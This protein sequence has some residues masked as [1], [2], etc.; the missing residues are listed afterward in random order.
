MSGYHI[1][2]HA[3]RTPDRIACKFMPSGTALTFGQL[4]RRSNRAAHL[5]RGLGL[6]RGDVIAILM[7]NHPRYYEIAWAAD[8]AGLYYTGISSRLTPSEIAYIIEDSGAAALFTSASLAN[9]AAEALQGQDNCTGFHVDGAAEG[10]RDYLVEVEELPDMPVADES[11]GA[12]MLYSSGTTGRPKGVKFPLPEGRIDQLDRLTAIT[13]ERFAY[14]DDMIYLSP[15]PLYHA[16]PLRWSMCAQRCGGTVVVM[17]KF[18]AESALALVESE[19]ITHSQWVPTHFIRMLKLPEAARTRHDLSS[20]RIAFHAAAPCP[21]PV[22]QAM[23]DWWGPILHEYYAGTEFN[24]LTSI[25]PEEWRA[26]PGSVGQ[27]SV[28]IIHICADDGETELSAREDGLVYFEGGSPFRYHNDPAKTSEAYN[29]KG[30]STLGDV[31]WVD[32]EGYLYL[33]D[34][35]S[36]MIISGGVN[37]YPQ[38][39][40]NA[41]IGHPKVAD[42]AVIGVPHEELGEQVIAVVQPM[43]WAD[44]GP[45]LA[46]DILTELGDVLSRL[47]MPRRIDFRAELPRHPT[48]KLYKRLLRDGYWTNRKAAAR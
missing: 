10:F 15:T 30:W 33:T 41:I 3:E 37:I 31:G 17:E 5:L 43:A 24:G 27:A 19:R 32:E 13:I 28:G 25:T 20:Q 2:A 6:K 23:L 26:H 42:V 8:R 44:A 9:I 18:D 45:D 46:A 47:K 7:E 16:A 48:G 39:I 4:D 36:F 21:V 1:A 12:P 14:G 38:E 29:S 40:E 22:K 34:R 11:C 35:K